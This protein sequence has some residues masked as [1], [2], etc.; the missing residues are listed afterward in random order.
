MFN[1]VGR[2]NIVVVGGGGAGAQ[3]ARALSA[4]LNPEQYNLLL[5]TARQHY[6]HLPAWIRMSVTDKG[7]LEDRAHI[8][9]NHIFHN[10]NGQLIV[11]KV[12]SIHSEEGDKDGYLVLESGENVDY[13]VL[14]LTPGSVWEGPL[15]IPDE[16]KETMD[17]LRTWRKKFA[18]SN[19]IVLVGGGAIASGDSSPFGSDLNYLNQHE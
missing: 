5:V 18:D 19:D 7:N 17:Q 2:P 4:T 10:G 13:S 8:T 1:M 3:V 6:T 16:K 11:G 12:A 14:V 15:D 9:Y